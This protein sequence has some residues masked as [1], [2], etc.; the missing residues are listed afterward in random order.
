[1]ETFAYMPFDYTKLLNKLVNKNIKI[2]FSV[3]E[4]SPY[5]AFFKTGTNEI[6]FNSTSA[7]LWQ[8]FIEELVHA[9]QYDIYGN[10]MISAIKNF[11][12]E[13]KAF[14]DLVNSFSVY[15]DTNTAMIEYRPNQSDPNTTFHS[16]YRMWIE[17][18]YDKNSFSSSDYNTYFELCE[19]W[20]GAP[21]VCNP[22]LQPQ[23]IQEFFRKPRPPINPNN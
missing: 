7:I 9:V 3:D 6:V 21:G 14:I 19:L 18:F 23:L 16:K 10:A 20:S 22:G 11:E 5:P 2:K 1:M 13:A 15:H 12:F 17:S 4:N 8:N